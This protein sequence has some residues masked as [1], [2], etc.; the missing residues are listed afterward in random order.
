MMPMQTND[1]INQSH[2]RWVDLI[3]ALSAFLVVLAHVE[4]SGSGSSLVRIFYYALT[5]VAVPMFFM[6]SG[7]LLLSKNEPYLEFFRKRFL[8]VFVPFIIWSVIYLIWKGELLDQPL[9]V[10]LKGYFVKIIRGPRENHLWFFYQL[11][12]LYLFTPILR[13]YV[14]K[15]SIKDL[16][17]FCGLW[18]LLTPL[19]NLIQE[20]TPIQIGFEYGFLNGYIGYFIFGYLT[21]RLEFNRSHKYIAMAVFFIHL[22]AT[23]WA[24]YLARYYEIRSQYFED[25]LSFN[26]V[27]MSCSLFIVLTRLDVPDLIDRL[28]VPLSRASF[29]IYLAHVIVMFQLFSIPAFSSLPSMGSGFYMIPLLGLLG[30]GLSFLLVFILQKIPIL[31]TIVP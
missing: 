14:Q 1:E 4:Y 17:Y 20:F 16:L 21:T 11:F 15:A 10:I 9:L 30:F 26:V 7:F 8:K 12:G 24:M 2:F 13:L 6:A 25:Y 28:T 19:A 22:V 5:R 18:F 23:T 27:L 31:K 3:R 29:G